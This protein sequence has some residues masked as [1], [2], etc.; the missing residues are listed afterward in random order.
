MPVGQTKLKRVK[1]MTCLS[2]RRWL[3]SK[4]IYIQWAPK[5]GMP[6]DISSVIDVIKNN[7]LMNKQQ[8]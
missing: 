5:S 6:T 1:R 4:V 7:I 2:Y 3:I 8:Q